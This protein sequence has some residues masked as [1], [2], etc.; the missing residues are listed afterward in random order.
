MKLLFKDTGGFQ[1]FQDDQVEAAMKDGWVDGDPI[2]QAIID[3]KAKDRAKSDTVT[4]ANP[5]EI[6]T[7][8]VQSEVKRSPGRPKKLSILN[9]GEI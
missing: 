2:R 4:I 5:P 9:D 6:A 1:N 7:M 8:P 3:A